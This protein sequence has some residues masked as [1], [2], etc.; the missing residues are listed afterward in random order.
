[1]TPTSAARSARPGRVRRHLPRQPEDVV[2]E[3]GR[4]ELFYRADAAHGGLDNIGFLTK[5]TLVAVQDFGDTAHGQTGHV[6]LGATRS[7]SAGHSP[8]PQRLIGEG[9][10][11][12]ATIDSQFLATGVAGFQNDGDNEIT[13]FH[14]SNGDPGVQR[15]ARREGAEAVPGRLARVLDP[16]AR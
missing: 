1:M 10:D 15:P 9:R 6:R 4:I 14:V 12:S 2:G 11:A 16:A 8:N 7:T 13:G 3:Q 5:R